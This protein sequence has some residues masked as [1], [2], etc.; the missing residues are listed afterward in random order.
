MGWGC[1]TV[2]VD[3]TGS[4]EAGRGLLC[5]R[6]GEAVSLVG[7]VGSWV[8]RF[9]PR[10]LVFCFSGDSVAKGLDSWDLKE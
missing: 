7:G 1:A 10:P 3:A 2:E 6:K 9:A 4:A 5:G 8:T